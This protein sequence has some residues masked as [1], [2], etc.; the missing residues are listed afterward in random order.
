MLTPLMDWVE[1]DVAPESILAVQ[2]SNSG[3]GGGFSDPTAGG[4]ATGEIVRTRPLCPYPLTQTYLGSGN[5]DDA[6]SFECALPAEE[7]LIDGHY[8]WVG[9]DLFSAAPEATAQ[10]ES[11]VA[12][13]QYVELQATV[14]GP[15]KANLRDGPGEDASILGALAAGDVVT[16]VGQS[17]AGDWIQVQTVLGEG[18]VFGELLILDGE[19]ESL[20]VVAP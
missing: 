17:A 16:A 1:N 20:P 10:T 9:N 19:A 13:T 6:A 7:N 8:E 3:S 18:W 14:A 12:D 15:R 5:I 4:G 2:T 11:D